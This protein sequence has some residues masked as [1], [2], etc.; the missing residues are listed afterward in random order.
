[1]PISD[2]KGIYHSTLVRAG[3]TVVTIKS[4]VLKSKY[5]GKPDY[6]YLT[7]ADGTE[8]SLAVENFRVAEALKGLKDQ[9]VTLRASGSREDAD[10]EILPAG[11]QPQTPAKP[12]TAPPQ[13][14]EPPKAAQTPEEAKRAAR[15]VAHQAML[16]MGMAVEAAQNLRAAFDSKYDKPMTPEHFQVITSSIFIFM[17]R[18]GAVAKLPLETADKE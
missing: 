13:R 12:A 16:G 3:D 17:D 14:Q 5:E 8:H 7:A 1:M 15:Q 2:K 11:D 10:L 6:V 18:S 4:D 9:R